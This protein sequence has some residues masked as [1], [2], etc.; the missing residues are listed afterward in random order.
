MP[1]PYVA[2]IGLPGLSVALKSA[3]YDVLAEGKTGSSDVAP[4]VRE[5]TTKG[6][7]YV[8][9]VAGEEPALRQWVTLQ[10]Q[11]N[12][13]V[14]IAHSELLPFDDIPPR[15]RTVEL[16]ADVDTI[17]GC[18]G[19]PARGAP[20]GS[21]MVGA[22]G[23]L[24]T[25]TEATERQND[26]QSD[27]EL[28]P[29]SPFAFDPGP[30]VSSA[31]H[32]DRLSAPVDS[33]SHQVV[34]IDEPSQFT[35]RQPTPNSDE[36]SDQ[37]LRPPVPTERGWVAPVRRSELI[38][39]TISPETLFRPQ[40]RPTNETSQHVSARRPLAPVII[41]LAGKGG[42]G[43]TATALALAQRAARKGGLGRVLIID[44]NRGQGDVRKYLRLSANTLPSIL[45]A[46]ISNEPQKAIL[47]PKQL[48]GARDDSMP[49]LAFGAVLAP[50]DEHANPDAVPTSAYRS[51]VD[52][53]RARFDVVVIDT[54]IVEASDTSGLIDD[55]IVPLLRSGAFGLALSDTSMAGVQNIFARVKMFVARGVSPDHMMLAVNRASPESGLDEELMARRSSHIATWIAMVAEDTAVA[56]AFER[57]YIP[58]DPDA[59]ETPAFTAMLDAALR[60]VTGLA[61]FDSHLASPATQKRPGLF[62]RRG[63]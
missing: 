21:V 4:A 35:E 16:P 62:R 23:T 50:D 51:V 25:E 61:V 14:L 2:V 37:K 40:I 59:R 12:V 38:P 27:T 48:N 57:G 1:R 31:T 3:G 29:P 30:T 20:S 42:V 9:I 15:A 28:P 13:A 63:R 34:V 6:V 39:E 32:E 33:V 19:A 36:S 26:E 49:P 10:L 58:G 46:A 22:D 55:L 41:T 7:A 60:R 24:L 11:R 56:E 52:Y 47:P 8:V 18:F 44:A 54:Q 43:K 53:A 5:A 17:M 45:D